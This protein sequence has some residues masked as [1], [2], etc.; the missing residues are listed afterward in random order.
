ML[1]NLKKKILDGFP[2]I[3]EAENNDDEEVSSTMDIEEIDRLARYVYTSG[4]TGSQLFVFTSG[5]LT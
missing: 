1:L 3:R 5:H 2:V 4:Q